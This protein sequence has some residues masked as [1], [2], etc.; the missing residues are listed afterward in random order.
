[1]DDFYEFILDYFKSMERS[2]YNPLVYVL[3]EMVK[4][5]Y[6]HGTGVATLVLV[7]T[8]SLFS[9]EFNDGNS[10]L[11]NFSSAANSYN[12]VKKSD[13]NFGHGLSRIT[14]ICKSCNINL[15]IDDTKGGINYS[16]LYPKI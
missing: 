7:D 2:F 4:N 14:D 8:P 15:T 10:D 9:F 1:M 16:G 3:K 12:W 5:I 11:I 13:R 6:D